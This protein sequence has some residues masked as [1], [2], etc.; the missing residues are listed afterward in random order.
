MGEC[1]ITA[2]GKSLTAVDLFTCAIVPLQEKIMRIVKK[3][4]LSLS[5]TSVKL[6]N[7]DMFSITLSP[8]FVKLNCGRLKNVFLLLKE[9]DYLSSDFFS[10]HLFLGFCLLSA[11]K[12]S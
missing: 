10:I 7:S 4:D 9:I 6:L 3:K 11:C 5:I 2:K 8:I 12:T 1:C